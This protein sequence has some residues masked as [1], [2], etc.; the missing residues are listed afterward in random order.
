MTIGKINKLPPAI[1][2]E[3]NRRLDNGEGSATILNWL[4][5]LPEVQAV[6]TSDFSGK[7]IC[8]R[9]LSEWRQGGYQKWVRHRE[10]LELAR[11]LTAQI[12]E[13]QPLTDRPISD[14]FAVLLAARYLLAFRKMDESKMDDAAHLKILREFC[15]DLVALRRGDHNAARL[16]LEQERHGFKKCKEP[17]QTTW[18]PEEQSQLLKNI[19]A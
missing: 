12:K 1:R 16:R 3:L 15:H 4:N 19:L 13:L 18:S 2:D 17:P 6:I 10:I 7:P 8:R 14:Q 11:E 9:N 5:E